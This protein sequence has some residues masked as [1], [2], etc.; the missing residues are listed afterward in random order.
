MTK[1]AEMRI[2]QEAIFKAFSNGTFNKF[3]LAEQFHVRERTIRRDL[4]VIADSFGPIDE[5]RLIIKQQA[6]DKLPSR[7]PKMSDSNLIKLGMS[8]ET[9]KVETT[10][11]VI[12]DVRKEYIFNFN[13]R[14]QDERDL[15]KHA[16]RVYLKG[17]SETRPSSIR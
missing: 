12:E 8:G 2:R 3:T 11:E 14:P 13:E 7:I 5:K 17:R 16:I 4:K 1:K 9:Q 10:T 15:I 6:L